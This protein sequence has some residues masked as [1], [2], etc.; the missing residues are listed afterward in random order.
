MVG[1]IHVKL[2]RGKYT[3]LLDALVVRDLDVA[4]LAGV[5]FN[6][7]NKCYTREEEDRVYFWDGG[8]YCYEEDEST[9]ADHIRSAQVLRASISE[10]V[11]PQ[12]CIQFETTENMDPD[13]PILVEASTSDD[14]WVQPQVTACVGK[15]IRVR[16]VTN[17][18][19]NI[20]KHEKPVK[21][22]PFVEPNPKDQLK[23]T[24]VTPRK[25][26]DRELHDI[27]NTVDV[28]PSG[29]LGP[30]LKQKFMKTNHQ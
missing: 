3:F 23:P 11:W 27:V 1:E 24:S 4:V 16:N 25:L 8:Y 17:T 22:T 19:I 10:T 12:E 26:T 2:H 18:P 21:V 30:E 20:K 28:D 6:K 29:I 5:P 15:T 9:R 14:S 7:K 13:I